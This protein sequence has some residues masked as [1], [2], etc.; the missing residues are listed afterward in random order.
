MFTLKAKETLSS[1]Q[2]FDFQKPQYNRNSFLK[3]LES[4]KVYCVW[5]RPFGPHVLESSRGVTPNSNPS[6]K[7]FWYTRRR[8]TENPEAMDMHFLVID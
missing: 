2:S 6:H 7:T 5:S 1:T 3:D 8:P 4:S